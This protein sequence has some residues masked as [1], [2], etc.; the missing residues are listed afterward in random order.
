MAD[1]YPKNAPDTLYI[2]SSYSEITFSDMMEQIMDH[3]G[4]EIDITTLTFEAEYIHTRCI[5]HDLHD[6]GDYDSYLVIR[7]R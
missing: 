7:K 6:S 5:G 1:N 2:H 3:F 4:Q